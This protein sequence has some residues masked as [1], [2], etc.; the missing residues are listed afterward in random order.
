M[1][2]NISLDYN[3]NSQKDL[4]ENTNNLFYNLIKSSYL[5]LIIKSL[6]I[7]KTFHENNIINLNQIY[8]N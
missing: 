1:F 5:V 2:F 3:K 8:D 7:E 6:F 4:N